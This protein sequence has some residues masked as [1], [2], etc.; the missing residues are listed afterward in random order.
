MILLIQLEKIVINKFIQILSSQNLLNAKTII[1]KTENVAR[2]VNFHHAYI[3]Y[4]NNIQ[5][6]LIA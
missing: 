3:S 5:R 2:T 6:S 4:N 1:L